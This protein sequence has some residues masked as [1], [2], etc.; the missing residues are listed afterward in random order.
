MRPD[1]I[2]LDGKTEVNRGYVR[3][4][5][6]PRNHS[7]GGPEKGAAFLFMVLVDSPALDP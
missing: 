5:A 7:E 4:V 2:W 6:G 3:M 1:V